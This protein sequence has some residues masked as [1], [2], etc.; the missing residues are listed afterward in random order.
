ML[1]H[2]MDLKARQ[3][4]DLNFGYEWHSGGGRSMRLSRSMF[5]C[6]VAAVFV[7]SDGVDARSLR[8]LSADLTAY[9]RERWN[10][11]GQIAITPPENWQIQLLFGFAGPFYRLVRLPGGA[12]DE[13]AYNHDYDAGLEPSCSIRFSGSTVAGRSQAEINAK[14][15][16]PQYLNQLRSQ[17]STQEVS[18]VRSFV[19]GSL[20][21]YQ[22]VAYQW[23]DGAQS[24]TTVLSNPKMA[25][26]IS[27]YAWLLRF[28]TLEDDLDA[29]AR[30]VLLEE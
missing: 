26:H 1:K 17:F 19:S 15:T 16:D 21:G 20:T 14:M 9:A 3:C 12:Y 5:L 23:S 22:V 30:G 24:V 13:S 11:E 29:V 2:R 27:C 25:A 8:D 18:S 7:T 28:P 6:L 10:V 4:L